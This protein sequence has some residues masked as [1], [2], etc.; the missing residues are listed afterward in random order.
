MLSL[1]EIVDVT[2]RVKAA[3]AADLSAADAEAARRQ[4][5]SRIE[6]ESFEATGLKSDVVTLYQGGQYHLYRYKRYTDLRLVFAPEKAIA[7]YGGDPDNFSFPR[8]CLDVC[9]F[10]IYEDGAPLE[11]EHYLRWS[12]AGTQEGELVFVAGHP[13]RTERLF[14]ADH[15]EFLRDVRYPTSLASLWRRE[16]QLATFSGRGNEY[17]RIAEDDLFGVQNSRKAYTGILSGALDPAFMASKRARDKALQAGVAADP[18]YQAQWGDAWDQI[19]AAQVAAREIYPRYVAAGGLRSELYSI[20]RHLVRLAEEKP[21]PSAE[22]LREYNDAALPSLEY[23]LFSP[24]PVHEALEIERVESGLLWMAERLGADDPTVQTALGGKAPRARAEELVK[25]SSLADVAVRRALY[26]GGQQAIEDSSDPLI[27]LARALDPE[28]RALRTRMENE[29]DS[30]QRQGYDKIAAAQFALE[31]EGQ[32]PDATFTLRLAFGRVAGYTE[33]GARVE[34]YTT[35]AGLYE[36]SAERKNQVPFALPESWVE[37]KDD[38]DLS[39]PYNFVNTCDIIGGNSGSPTTNAKNEVVGLIF[40]GNIQSLI[41]DLAYTDEQGRAV[42]VD[43]RAI[44]AALRDVYGASELAA[45]LAEPVRAEQPAG[46][47]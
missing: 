25:G 5:L 11:A 35:F 22:R 6:Q 45:E 41:A 17:A 32:Y 46:S 14:T 12:E 34:P 8:Y 30:V 40:D 27:Q 42:S 2:E 3:A 33:D 36:K 43:S 37:H 39:T 31:G 4:E 9:F 38:L 26:E 18:E 47:F 15:V 20:A 29:V 19:R 7:F 23:G 1:W 13:G 28:A 44:L 10:R 16:V 21:K 24:A